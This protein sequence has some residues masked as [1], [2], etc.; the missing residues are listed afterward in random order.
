MP[1]PRWF[2]SLTKH[3]LN[4]RE[5]RAGRRPV[6]THVGRVSGAVHRTP[7]DAHPTAAGWL[8]VPVYG[9]ESDWCRN[10]LSAGAATL[11]VDGRTVQ[12]TSPRVV[13]RV[14][15]KALLAGEAKMP[16]A[17]LRIREFLVMDEVGE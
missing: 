14:E 10:I 5:L 2:T 1:M 9:I 16:A 7:L 8:F 13:D 3:V 12:L 11:S 4:P 6:L 15:A 17:V